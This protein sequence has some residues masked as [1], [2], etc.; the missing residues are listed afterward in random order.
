MTRQTNN[1][2]CTFFQSQKKWRLYNFDRITEQKC[3]STNQKYAASC[4]NNGQ[5]LFSV[6]IDFASCVKR[7][8]KWRFPFNNSLSL[9]LALLASNQIFC[10]VLFTFHKQIRPAEI[11]TLNNSKALEELIDVN[12]FANSMAKLASL[13]YFT[14]LRSGKVSLTLILVLPNH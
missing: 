7:L 10:H 13:H 2:P 4:P 5:K 1:V 11:C 14:F 12:C 8:V 6:E 9:L 3:T